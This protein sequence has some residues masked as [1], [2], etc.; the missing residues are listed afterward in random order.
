AMAYRVRYVMQFNAREAVHL[1][2]LRSGSQGHPAY[3]RIALEMHRLI[4]EQAGH[5][6]IA[7]AMTHL[8]TEAPA[9][10]RLASERRAE[11]RRL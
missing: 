10:E 6:A 2:E 4:A 7:A 5:T 9:L 3:R 8:T 1:I 11:S